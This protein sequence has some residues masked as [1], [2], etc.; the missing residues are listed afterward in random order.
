[1]QESRRS[2]DPHPHEDLDCCLIRIAALPNA[3]VV[4]GAPVRSDAVIAEV[5]AT[6]GREARDPSP[7]FMAMTPCTIIGG[8]RSSRFGNCCH[9]VIVDRRP[10]S[11]YRA[12]IARG[13]A[14]S[15]CRVSKSLPSTRLTPLDTPPGHGSG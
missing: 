11:R 8:G 13:G 2:S 1:M 5:S 12:L 14:L 6:T 9:R 3:L 10:L 4:F 7:L 15:P